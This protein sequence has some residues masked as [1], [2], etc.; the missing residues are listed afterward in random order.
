[1]NNLINIHKSGPSC[2]TTRRLLTAGSPEFASS[3][4]AVSIA[5]ERPTRGK[6]PKSERCKVIM[7]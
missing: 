1:M 6:L 3:P 4:L 7:L 2:A 5:P